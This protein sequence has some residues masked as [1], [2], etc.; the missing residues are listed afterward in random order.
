MYNNKKIVIFDWGGIVESHF[1][2]ENNCYTAKVDILNRLNEQTKT[3]SEENIIS[4]WSECDNDENGK[5]IGEVNDDI[6]VQ[7]WFERIKLKFNLKCDYDEFFKV[8]Q[9]ESDKIK[10]YKNVVEFAHSLK[11]KC[12]IG[13]LS[14]LMALDKIRIDKHYN[15][16]KFDYVWLSFELN[17]RKPNEEIYKIVEEQCKISKENILFIDDKLENIEAAQRRGW[18]VCLASA[19]EFE[20][21]KESVYVF[22]ED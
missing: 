16:S 3:Y 10:Y 9:E 17:C 6:D 18:N 20:K 14:N 7:K 12:K 19:L 5:G 13:I 11:S 8:Y 22:L 15:L 2:G 1:K 4:K 21:I